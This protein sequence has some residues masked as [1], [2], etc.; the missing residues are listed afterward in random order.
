MRAKLVNNSPK[1]LVVVFDPGD[2]A[3]TGLL[4][5]A[6]EHGL[7]GAQITGLGAFSSAKLA[8][9]D[10]QTKRYE[11]IA[12]DEQ[13]EVASLVGN[14]AL[15]E[16]GQTKIHVHAVLSRRNGSAIAGHLLEGHVQPTL[17]VTFIEAPEALR[18]KV[19]PTTGLPLL[20]P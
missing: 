14:V 1:T 4:R 13:V 12:V 16:D 6:S 18:R 9:F 7:R 3:A 8:F 2:E 5:V 19:D 15:T 10:L 20:V 17:E 11:P